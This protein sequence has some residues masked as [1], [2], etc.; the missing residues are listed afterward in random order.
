MKLESRTSTLQ[1]LYADESARIRKDFEES[2]DGKAAIRDR[3]ALI[4]SVVI[5]LW[6]EVTGLTDPIKGFCIAAMGGYGRRALFPYSDIDLLFLYEKEGREEYLSKR[7]IAPLSQALWDLHLRVSPT[8]RTLAECGKLHRH[9]IEFNISLLDC[10]YICG[11]EQ[12]Y[13]QLRSRVLPGMVVRESQSL[14]QELTSLARSRHEKYGQTIFHLEPNI[15]D[16]PGGLRDYQVTCW[17]AQI[18]EMRR[19]REWKPAD[20]LLPV[21]LRADAANAIDFLDAVRC[22]LHYRQG[23]DL[24]VLTYELQSE[25][26]AKGIGL[27]G[28]EAAS[29]N[30]WMRIYFR[31][32]RA[33]DR[34]T[35]AFDEVPRAKSLWSRIL[36]V[37]RS[38]LSTLEFTVVD[39]RVSLTKPEVVEDP[40]AI[41]RLFRLV[42]AHN[43][44]LTAET[45]NTVEAT[46]PRIQ[47]WISTTTDLWDHFREILLLP[48]AA[49][50]L[51]AMHRL[52]FL[53]MMFKELHAI[54]SLVIR[55]YYHRYT[56]DEHSL[57]TIENLHNL[58]KASSDLIGRFRDIL[59][60]LER[61]ELLYLALLFHDVGKG[62]PNE[63]HVEG[64]LTAV[65]GVFDRL[66]LDT[67]GRETVNFLIANHLRMSATLMRRDIF[68]PEA[69]H[70]FAQSVGTIEHLKMLTL[71]TYADIKAVNPEALTPWKAE[72][73]W[74][75][76]AATEN[77]LNRS[78]DDQR[79]YV[80]GED[81]KQ[82]ER[83]IP[84][85]E[86]SLESERFRN[87][88][89][90][91]PRRYLLTHSPAE[92]ATHY[93]MYRRLGHS[94]AEISVTKRNEYYELVLVTTDRPFLFSKIAGTI[95]SWGMNILKA[96]ACANKQGIVLDSLRFSDRFRTLDH[97][98]S[99]VSRLKQQ[100]VGA[101]SGE[102]DVPGL[103]KRKFQPERRPPKVRVETRIHLDDE[104]SSHSTVVEIVALDRP[105]LLY[106]ISSTFAEL[107]LNINVG[108]IDTEGGTATDVFYVTQKG[109]KLSTESQHELHAA[110]QKRLSPAAKA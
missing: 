101:I 4:D 22:F 27:Q 106:D 43:L 84:A 64:S 63:S 11:D 108:L 90:G 110:L 78:V 57:V 52:G 50:A 13:A 39:G 109:D 87:Y 86:D 20:G 45:E 7:I 36:G 55:D 68:D 54:E 10:R 53:V 35:V 25:A 24:N 91:F 96:D 103:M 61:P 59:S 89:D 72:M 15:K 51:R 6:N 105:G 70:D 81:P 65:L 69:V 67:L 33:I 2:G 62:M 56:V 93:R 1:D 9:N 92:I 49:A 83:L 40:V 34:L 19:S 74:Q 12:L 30:D 29:P 41:F 71:F 60:T 38:P 5:E 14:M 73:I 48:Y 75:L 47:K 98:P 3:T 16:G 42:G 99:E 85:G 100:L 80:A 8:T 77:Y 94:V 23:R 104:C 21:P 28:G 107:N 82:F 102:L 26:A 58:S 88:L 66:Q 37:R 79:L 95:S 17:L 18:A 31:R 97:N 76:Y 32:A 46:L 44:K